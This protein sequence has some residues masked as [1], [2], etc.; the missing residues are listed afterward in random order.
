MKLDAARSALL[1]MDFQTTIVERHAIGQDELLGATEG[2]IAAARRSGMRL[3][4][5]VVGFRPG[6]PEVSSQTIGSALSRA[7]T[8]T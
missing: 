5:V 4:Y 1:V 6:L 7:P 2:V 8:S 3:I